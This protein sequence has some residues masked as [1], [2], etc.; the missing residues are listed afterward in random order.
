VSVLRM[1][2]HVI[3]AFLFSFRGNFALVD[4]RYVYLLKFQLSCRVTEDLIL[5]SSVVARFL[6]SCSMI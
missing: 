3:Y 1:I 5:V 6:C 2:C 4:S